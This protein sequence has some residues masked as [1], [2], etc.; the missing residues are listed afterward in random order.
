MSLK[1][2]IQLYSVREPLNEDFKGTLTRLAEMGFQGVEFAFNYGGLEPEELATFLQEQGLRAIGIY[3][4]PQN[5]CDPDAEVYR[6]ADAL[7]CEHLT[8]GFPPAIIEDDFDDCLAI[9]RKAAEVATAKGKTPCYHAHAHEFVKLNGEYKLDLILKNEKLAFEAD[10]CW[11]HQGGEDVV[12]YM[13]K[14]A[15]KIPLLHVKDVTADGTITE[16]GNGVIDFSA[17]VDFAKANGVPWISYE[18]DST[19]LTPMESAQIS[20]NHLKNCCQ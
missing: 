2:G 16:L 15:E 17:V 1:I 4:N 19:T 14:Y 5:I 12:G 20:I 13:R 10:T 9:C 7:G 18:Q 8:F 6:Q 3:E 11:I